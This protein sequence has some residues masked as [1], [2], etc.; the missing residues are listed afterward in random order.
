M[1]WRDRLEIALEED[2]PYRKDNLPESQISGPEIATG[3][4]RSLEIPMPREDEDYVQLT[5]PL[6]DE[7]PPPDD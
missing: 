1:T 7:H 3:P 4:T 6:D 2:T 5:I